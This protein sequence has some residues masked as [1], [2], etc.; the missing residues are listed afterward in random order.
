MIHPSM[1]GYFAASLRQEM[2]LDKDVVLLTGD[3]GYGMLDSIRDS[4]PGQFYNVGAAEQSLVGIAVGLALSGKKPFVYSITPFLLCR[5]FEWLR[6][7]VQHEGIPVRMVGSGLDDDYRHDGIT[8]RAF[9][10]RAILGLFPGIV[11]YFPSS[12]EEI[13]GIVRRMCDRQEPAFVALRR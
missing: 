10:A 3:L 4:F 1:R 2:S 8:H 6:N 7:Y 5:P 12:K 11:A 13:P 9:D